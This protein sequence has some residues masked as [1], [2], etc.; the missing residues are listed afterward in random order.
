MSMRDCPDE[1]MRDVLPDYVRG[2]LDTALQA[3]VSAHLARC[4]DCASEVELLRAVGAALVAPV[5]NVSRIVAA[6]P[7]PQQVAVREHTWRAH[8]A[9][10]TRP[11]QWL[12]AAGVSFVLLGGISWAALR[13]VMPGDD[14]GASSTA[15]SGESTN[16]VD[17]APAGTAV[18]LAQRESL[19]RVARGGAAALSF[20]GGLS[21]LTDE[22][23][24]TL[25]R[26]LESLDATLKAEPDTVTTPIISL[27]EGGYDA[28]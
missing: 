18:R 10:R 21:D 17:G 14:A 28:Q 4:S 3:T 11:Q 27:R 15:T 9:R 13:R 20:G 19:T 26:E 22:A 12:L 7:R 5:P 2:R 24:Q 23:L 6:L 25:L 1:T 8:V 16:P